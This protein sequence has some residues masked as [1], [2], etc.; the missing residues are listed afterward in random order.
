MRYAHLRTSPRL[1]RALAALRAHPGGLTTREWIQEA[2]I[3][4]CNSIAAELKAN[5]IPVECRYEGRSHGGASVFRY[6]LRGKG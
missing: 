3:C 5:G 4:A 2:D 6:V 1:Q